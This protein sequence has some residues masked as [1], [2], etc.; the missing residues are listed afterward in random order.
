MKKII[1][2]GAE[3]IISKSGKVITKDRIKKSYRFQEL[4][5]KIRKRRTKK[6]FNILN[7][8]LKIIPVPKTISSDLKKEIKLLKSYLDR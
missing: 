4:D 8:T 6:E 2:Q 1:I 7:K 5:E 3:A